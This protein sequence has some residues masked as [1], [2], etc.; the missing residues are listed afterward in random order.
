[1]ANIKLNSLT[2]LQKNGDTMDGN[3][4]MASGVNIVFNAS[5]SNSIGSQSSTLGYLFVDNLIVDGVPISISGMN[6]TITNLGSG[7]GIF[8]QQVMNDFQLKSLVSGNGISLSSDSSN[9]Y[10]SVPSGLYQLSGDYLIVGT[11][12]DSI[13]QGVVNLYYSDALVDANPNLNSISGLAALASGNSTQALNEIY[14]LSGTI[15]SQA[16]ELAFVSGVA[17]LASGNASL[18]L[19]EIAL[20]SGDATSAIQNAI[21][22]GNG[23]DVFDSQNGNTLQ[24][25]SVSGLG[26]VNVTLF[27]NVIQISGTGAV[28]ENYVVSGTSTVLN[29]LDV[30]VLSGT[31]ISGITGNFGTINVNTINAMT[32]NV[33]TINDYVFSGNSV[34][35][36]NVTAVI[37]MYTPILSG[38]T[39]NSDT[40]NGKMGLFSGVLN[41][42]VVSGTTISGNA[43]YENGLQVINSGIGLGTIT[44]TQSGSVLEIS[45]SSYILPS[46][47]FVH[48]SGDT[49]SGTLIIGNNAIGPNLIVGQQ[50]TVVS[51]QS[52]MALGYQNL[53]AGYTAFA[54][55]AQNVV[56]GTWSSAMGSANIIDVSSNN[57][58]AQGDINKIF[59]SSDSH[60]EGDSNLIVN[61][62]DA[63]IEGIQNIISGSQAGHA[64]GYSNQVFANYGHGEGSN[65]IISGLNSH[66]EGESN[67]AI[68][69]SSH[70]EGISNMALGV[71]SHAEGNSGNLASGVGSHVEG[72]GA[73]W[74]IG[75]YCHSEGV[76]S[77]AY[78][79]GSHVE[80]VGSTTYTT[81]SYAAHAEGYGSTAQNTGTHAQG[82]NTLAAGYASFSAG[83]ST[84]ANGY[85]SVAIG[86]TANANASGSWIFSDATTITKNNNIPNSLSMIFASGVYVF[87]NLYENGQQVVNS[88]I[89]L[90]NVTIS[91]NGSVLSI[92]GTQYVLPT[93]VTFTTVDATTISG[94]IISG[95]S[96]WLSGTQFIPSNYQP[97]GNYVISGSSTILN[98]LDVT[99]LSGTTISGNAFYLNGVPLINYTLPSNLIGLT[100]VDSM[101][102]SGTTISG[103]TINSLINNSNVISG[104]IISGQS[105]YEAGIQVANA[106]TTVNNLTSNIT[107]GNITISG[108]LIPVFTTVNAQTVSGTTI[109]GNAI[110][111]SGIQIVPSNYQPTGNYVVSGSSTILSI[112]DVTV[113]SGTTISGNAIYE[114]GL[115]VINAVSGLGTVVVNQ[116]GSTVTVSGLGIRIT[117]QYDEIPGGLINGSNKTY[118][119]VGSPYGNSLKLF[120][121]GIL[122]NQSGI[123]TSTIDYSLSANIIT[124]LN[125]PLTNTSLVAN[126][127]FLN[128]SG[129]DITGQYTTNLNTFLNVVTISA[130]YI[131]SN[132]NS[133]ILCNTSG[134]SFQVTLPSPVSGMDLNIKKISNDSNI[135]TVSGISSQ[136]IDGNLTQTII[137]QYTSLEV[138]SD[139]LNWYII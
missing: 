79:Y 105:I 108:S 44:V 113:L 89:G 36:N 49:M 112:L 24:F 61:S 75:D 119:L 125:A 96:L 9:I 15:S 12:T 35:G 78:G 58:Y 73:N 40:I 22:L 70:V 131:A 127:V 98:I 135:L 71:G 107:N 69:E 19:A 117:N 67:S 7:L 16:N 62:S 14:V 85:L 10:I 93:N 17:A 80:G 83:I 60:A 38:T 76:G 43:I 42:S 23:I 56:S 106:V 37:Q 123:G 53:V 114:N 68:A 54:Q 47:L 33:I 1:M 87:G 4:G 101:V 116:L 122:L 129:A 27:G 51:N 81:A 137:S 50:N 29:V 136:T 126:Y 18:A 39:I 134:A 88:G 91:Q 82:I 6:V 26:N 55:G 124:M 97:S 13:P 100:L 133:V 118:T 121:D 138:V 115:Q 84:S 95:N 20:I 21:N 65:N 11:T 8:S 41:A 139:G 48:I 111:A 130:N 31:T 86:N 57:S 90:G 77:D 32:E 94:T 34:S 74:A 72:G 30:S 46:G 3:L 59:N 103:N 104:S 120:Q 64:E 63:H 109:S 28:A 45:G 110:F 92:S 128:P 99:V 5:G 132:T 66:A 2:F 102:L 25:N 52:A